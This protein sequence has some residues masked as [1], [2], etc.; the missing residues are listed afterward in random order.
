MKWPE[1]ITSGKLLYILRHIVTITLS[2]SI[3]VI[4][5][6]ILT[7]IS[8]IQ[9]FG[10]RNVCNIIVLYIFHSIFYDCCLRSPYWSRQDGWKSTQK[11]R[12]SKQVI[13][14]YGRLHLNIWKNLKEFFNYSFENINRNSLWHF[15]QPK[16]PAN[17]FR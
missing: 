10:I 1:K 6:S 14:V 9:R 13:L 4:D 15:Y 16:S 11:V 17:R 3:S 2:Q 12:V 5:I 7:S 8:D